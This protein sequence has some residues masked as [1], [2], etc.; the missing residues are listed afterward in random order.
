MNLTI[1]Y[2]ILGAIL[3]ISFISYFFIEK[4]LMKLLCSIIICISIITGCIVSIKPVLDNTNYGLDLQG[5]F[6]V[7]YQISPIK[8]KSK[9]TS[10]M[11]YN[12]YQSLVRRI[13][14]LGVSEPEITIE[15]E[16]KIRVKL[17]GIKNKDQAREVLSSTASL[18]FRDTSDHLLMT[19]DVLGGKAKVSTDDRGRPAVSLSIKDKDTFY[20]VTSKIS[21]RESNVIV[22]WLDYDENEDSYASE[23]DKCGSLN[24]SHCLSAATVSQGFS[25]DVIISGSFTSEE[26]SSLVELI[27][28]GAL[29]TKLTEISSRTVEASFGANSLEK[30]MTAGVIGIGIVILIML[31]VYKFSGFIASMGVIM[32]TALTFLIFYLLNGVLTLPGIAAILLGIGMAVD[33]N[34]ISFERIKEQIKIGKSTKEAFE[35]GNKSSLTSIIDAN[36]TTLIAAIIIFILGQ[37]SVKG[38]ATM[39]IISIIVTVLV[40]VFFTKFILRMFVKTGYFENKPNLFIGVNKKKI[41]KADEIDIPFQKLEFVKTR[42]YFLSITCLII[43]VGLV[44]AFTKGANLGVDFTGGTSITVNKNEKVKLKSIEDELKE[45]NYHIKKEEET[46]KDIT[47]VIKDVLDKGDI[48]TLTNTIEKEY[49]TDTDIYT[50]S[51]IVKQELTKNAIY[52]VVLAAIGILIYVSIRFKYNYAVAAVIALVHDVIIITLFFCIFHLEITTMFIAAILTI[53]GYSI[54]DTIVTFDMIR[55]NYKKRIANKEE[56]QKLARKENKKNKNK[57]S[58]KTNPVLAIFNDED[59]VE[60]VNDSVRITFFR[61]LLT[62]ITTIFPVICLMILGAREIVNFN[63]ALLIGF[64]AGVYS[65]IFISNQIWLILET[66]SLKKPKKEK[67]DDDDEVEEIK[68]KGVNC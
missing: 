46:S 4:K 10:E 62:T 45:L 56:E 33:A 53:I 1:F 54:N 67:K 5:G 35:I 13:D 17:A 21:K 36:I 6:E 34:V 11:V 41:H 31:L 25:S 68:I 22:I 23:K 65:S 28:S 61:S 16:N 8:K 7:L 49:D 20:D 63:I 19:S 40:M 2:I 66:R 18:T 60:L 57:T 50:V 58:K 15:G 47:I 51:K 30:T 24:D 3:L 12:T 43:I 42:K 44:V 26:A 55:E 37:S 64:I 14:I 38:F 52:S 9:L 29:P 32:Y 27:N 48:K 39:L 59:L